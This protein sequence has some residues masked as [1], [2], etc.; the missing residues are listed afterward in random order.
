ML[1]EVYQYLFTDASQI[2]LTELKCK[3]KLKKNTKVLK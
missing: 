2:L 3:E 1:N